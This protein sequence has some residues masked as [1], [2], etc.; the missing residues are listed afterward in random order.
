MVAFGFDDVFNITSK[1]ASTATTQALMLKADNK[2]LTSAAQRPVAGFDFQV[3]FPRGLRPR[4]CRIFQPPSVLLPLWWRDHNCQQIGHGGR[5][6]HGLL[7]DV[8]HAV[9][10]LRALRDLG[11]WIAIDDFGTGYSSLA[12][13]RE[14]PVT[15]MKIEDVLLG[16]KQQM[17]IVLVTNLVQQAHRLADHVAFLNN[18]S[19][20]EVDTTDRIFSEHPAQQLTFDYVRGHFG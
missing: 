15:T 13:L 12:Y 8:G 2:L 10:T 9:E 1:V 4:Q 7:H 5:L 17:T 19:L 3:V 14:L 20:V 18:S 6:G 16:L 11:V